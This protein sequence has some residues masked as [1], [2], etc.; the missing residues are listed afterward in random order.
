MDLQRGWTTKRLRGWYFLGPSAVTDS[1]TSL[2]APPADYG[3]LNKKRR[4][5]SQGMSFTSLFN[6]GTTSHQLDLHRKV[7]TLLHSQRSLASACPCAAD[8]PLDVAQKGFLPEASRALLSKAPVGGATSTRPKLRS[9]RGAT[10]TDNLL[11]AMHA[12]IFDFHLQAYLQEGSM[13]H[14]LRTSAS[15]SPVAESMHPQ[16]CSVPIRLQCASGILA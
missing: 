7:P 2:E 9:S 8:V 11:A 6:R 14:D 4:F 10:L 12:A 3:R 1:L 15:A 13:P 5:V 16:R